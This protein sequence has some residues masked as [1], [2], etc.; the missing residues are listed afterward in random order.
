MSDERRDDESLGRALGRAIQSQPVRET[1]YAASRLARRLDRPPVRGWTYALPIAAAL[2]LF[3]AMGA[4][5]ASR[6]PQGGVATPDTSASPSISATTGPAPTPTPTAVPTSNAA[7]AALV[8]FARDLLPPVGALVPGPAPFRTL[9]AAERI[10][11]RVRALWDARAP[12]GLGNYFRPHVGGSSLA[13]VTTTISGDTA[14]VVIA[15]GT[16]DSQSSAETGGLVAQLVYTITDEPGIRR[17]ALREP[18]KDHMVIGT[19]ILREPLTREDVNG[20]RTLNRVDGGAITAGDGVLAAEVV[21]WR[22]SAED[23][24][25][26]LGR[27]VVELK[28]MTGQVPQGFVP[29]LTAKLEQGRNA[30]DQE[31]GK[32]VLRLELPDAY[33]PPTPGEAFH[34]C[35]F[36]S[37]DKTPIRQVSAYPL[38][39]GSGRPGVSFAV[40]LDDARP[41]RVTVMHSPL[42]VVVDIGGHPDAVS[43]SIA[44]YSP[45]PHATQDQ[46]QR[47][48]GGGWTFTVS[49]LARAFEANVNWRLRDSTNAVVASGNTTAS[50]G[51]SAVWGTFQTGV[52]VPASVSGNVT[53]EVFWGSPRDG[54]DVGLVRI[55]LRIR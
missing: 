5:F 4:F 55:P 28:A 8:Y 44:V 11:A 27:F 15:A 22:A 53:L 14:T 23:V 2:A 3:V 30:N 29:R 35:P 31:P 47:G 13:N 17:A 41:W 37:V 48:Q 19:G 51:T 16:W 43:E 50:I 6:G 21:D 26:G 40:A 49:G 20:Y 36:K 38:G 52:T 7:E 34:C 10:S 33:W 46:M 42:R 45:T 39:T 9:P 1:P 12:S 32:Y 25:P 54:S 18:G 24:A